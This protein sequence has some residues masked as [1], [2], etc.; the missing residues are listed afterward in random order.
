MSIPVL[1]PDSYLL[2][3]LFSCVFALLTLQLCFLSFGVLLP[4]ILPVYRCVEICNI[5]LVRLEI[6]GCTGSLITLLPNV[7][8]QRRGLNRCTS[9]SMTPMRLRTHDKIKSQK[10]MIVHNPQNI[11]RDEQTSIQELIMQRLSAVWMASEPE[12]R[13]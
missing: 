1:Q 12:Q 13:N 6:S 10:P 2:A 11:T 7:K 5:E 3:G 9:S 4:P 8:A